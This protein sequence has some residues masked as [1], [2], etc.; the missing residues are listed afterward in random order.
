[1]G[2]SL[3]PLPPSG[4]MLLSQSPSAFAGEQGGSPGDSPKVPAPGQCCSKTGLYFRMAWGVSLVSTDFWSSLE[5]CDGV[6]QE[7]CCNS[8]STSCLP[9]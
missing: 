2:F 5:I 8:A 1:M 6:T 3:G 9:V 4:E 7:V